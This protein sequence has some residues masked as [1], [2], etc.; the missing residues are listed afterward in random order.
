MA[1]ATIYFSHD[2]NARNDRKLI[3]LRMNHSVAGIGVYWCV[4]EMLYEEGGYMPLEYERIAF[5]LRT[6]SDLVTDVINSYDLFKIDGDRFYSQA[7]LDRI[8][9]QFE[10]SEKAK[11]SASYRWGKGENANALRPQT[12]R[13]AKKENK[14]KEKE[15]KENNTAEKRF[16]PPELSAVEEYCKLRKNSVDAN[17]W[18]DYYE[19]KGW[20]IGKSPMKDWKAAVRTWEHNAESS[21]GKDDKDPSFVVK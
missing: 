12:E 8:S 10:K 3:N 7:V 11:Q 18:Y 16:T 20:L 9:K 5:D 1:K 6:D 21:F 2:C 19:S 14:I 17:R 4:V 15:I 13:Y